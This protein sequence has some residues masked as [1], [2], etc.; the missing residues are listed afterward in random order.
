MEERKSDFLYKGLTWWKT[1]LDILIRTLA[2]LLKWL[3]KFD[4]EML[5]AFCFQCDLQHLEPLVHI[6]ESA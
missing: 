5:N 4:P 1:D 3:I 2:N 6:T